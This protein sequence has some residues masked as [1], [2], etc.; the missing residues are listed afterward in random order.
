M[1]IWMRK[2]KEFVRFDSKVL[3]LVLTGAYLVFYLYVRA[4]KG[5]AEAILVI[6]KIFRHTQFP[7]IRRAATRSLLKTC[8]RYGIRRLG[9][10][11]LKLAGE[12][13]SRETITKLSRSIVD[14]EDCPFDR[15][16]LILSPP[17]GDQRGVL[18]IKFTDYFKSFLAVFDMEKLCRDY[19][20][21][22]EPS[23]SGYFDEDI[24]C[25]LS[26]PGSVVIEASEREDYRFIES[27]RSDI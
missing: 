22:F 5:R 18:I 7:W 11:F 26:V 12:R 13:L 2:A 14:E 8:K 23:Y 15:R 16:L 24:L 10:E 3:S 6:G 19:V 25:L 21:V 1:R 17:L 20:A 9:D 4:R 27:L